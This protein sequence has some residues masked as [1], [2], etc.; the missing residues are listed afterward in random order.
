MWPLERRWE[1]VRI[2]RTCVQRW[3]PVAGGRSLERETPLPAQ[4]MPPLTA[5]ESSLESVLREATREVDVV[6]ESAWLPLMVLRTGGAVWSRASVEALARHRMTELYDDRGSTGNPIHGDSATAWEYIVDH[7]PGDDAGVAYGLARA[8]KSRVEGACRAAGVRLRSIQPALKWGLG[9]LASK[10]P[11]ALGR[12]GWWLWFEQDRAVVCR[13]QQ[14][15]VVAV[16]AGASL[17]SDIDGCL[18]TLQIESVRLGLPDAPRDAVVAGWRM[19]FAG[20]VDGRLV[21]RSLESPGRAELPV[22]H[23]SEVAA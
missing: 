19:P 22:A 8:L 16:N 21:V 10:D 7:R 11:N 9:T 6:I 18:R 20:S 17:P 1:V 4:A 12:E 15:R 2:G 13:L 14:G 23:P 3:A 5:L